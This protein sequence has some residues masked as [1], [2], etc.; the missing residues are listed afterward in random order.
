[1]DMILNT[2][3]QHIERDTNLV[4]MAT[5]IGKSRQTLYNYLDNLSQPDKDTALKIAQYLGVSMDELFILDTPD[6]GRTDRSE[7]ETKHGA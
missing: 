4:D 3:R 6:D 2:I 5:H 7:R 1:M